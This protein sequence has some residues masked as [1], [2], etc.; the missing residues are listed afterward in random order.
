MFSEDEQ[1]VT[2]RPFAEIDAAYAPL[3]DSW[4]LGPM[5]AR[6]VRR[7]R[8]SRTKTS[9]VLFVSPRIRFD[10]ADMK[11]TRLPSAEI[12]A[13]S[14]YPM[15]THDQSSGLRPFRPTLT[16]VNLRVLRS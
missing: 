7:R 6:A 4:P 13:A 10:A 2:N 9:H 3:S 12:S 1:K 8:R 5:L 14:V 16:H 15:I 11:T